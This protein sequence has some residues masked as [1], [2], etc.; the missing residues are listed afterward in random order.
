[1][2]EVALLCAA[3]VVLSIYG[4]SLVG[5]YRIDDAYITFSY[6]KN[7][8][9]GSGPVY[10]L[11]M[12]VEGY[13]NFLW[14][15]F[16]AVGE[17]LH[18]DPLAFARGLGVGFFALTLGST[19][20]VAR[21][22]GG[23][24]SAAVVTLCLAS[25]SDFHRAI[26]SGLETLGYCGFI[27]AGLCHYLHEKPAQRRFSLLWFAA[28]ALTRIDGIVPLALIILLEGVRWL[29]EEAPRK[30]DPVKVGVILRWVALGVLPVGAYWLWRASYYG[31]LFPLTYYAKASLAV[32]MDYRGAAYV[33]N[34]LQDSG[35]WI[36]LLL[37]VFALGLGGGLSQLVVSAFVVGMTGY[38]V[39]VGGDWMPFNRM[40]LPMVP[41]LFM[42]SAFSLRSWAFSW[43]SLKAPRAAAFALAFGA[44]HALCAVYLSQAW[45]DT[46][47]EQRKLAEA[48]HHL[49]HTAGLLKARPFVNA[50]IRAPSDKL[51]TDYGGVFAYG[52]HATV[53]EMWGLANR[54][55]ALRGNTDGVAAIYGKTCVP[56]YAEFQPD[57]FHSIVPLL[58][59]PNDFRNRRQLIHQIFQGA[60]IDRVIGLQKNYVLG[61]VMREATGETLWFLERKREGVRFEKRTVGDLTVDYPPSR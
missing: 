35:L 29:F 28:A 31:L 9:E 52:T 51:V 55:I 46:P 25:S 8:A 44:A 26:Q 34:G 7:L 17:M 24:V 42:L 5:D 58:R 61:R 57:Y 32:E 36:P 13:S 27:A 30:G 4:I 50:L 33:W 49:N 54:D 19:W 48:T 41:P 14:M 2:T 23:P 40:L 38:V 43:D 3:C 56:C 15:I 22:W 16:V 21:K 53:I 12:R 47:F 45:V 11:D 6:S 10:G 59:G 37:S 60:A 39:H 18:I 20:L 1:M